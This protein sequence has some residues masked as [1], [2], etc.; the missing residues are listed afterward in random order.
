MKI[1]GDDLVFTYDDS[2]NFK[3]NFY[4]WYSMNTKEKETWGDK[5]YKVNEALDIFKSM[6]G[7]KQRSEK[8][9]Y[10]QLNLFS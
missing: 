5:P 7:D 9:I 8:G 1:C 4:R 6:W 2:Q 10:R 3:G